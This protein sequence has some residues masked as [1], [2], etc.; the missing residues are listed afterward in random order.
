[1]TTSRD[2]LLTPEDV[3]AYLV[4]PV[5][6]LADW[7]TKRTGPAFMRMGVHVRYRQSDIDEY[8]EKLAREGKRWLAS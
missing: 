4:I 5:K 6:T 3:S 2:P 7:R 8:V 1:M